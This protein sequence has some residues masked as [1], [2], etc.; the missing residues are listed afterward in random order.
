M[1]RLDDKIDAGPMITYPVL[2]ESDFKNFEFQERALQYLSIAIVQK[3]KMR[4]AIYCPLEKKGDSS[5]WHTFAEPSLPTSATPEQ[6][7]EMKTLVG[8]GNWVMPE[9]RALTGIVHQ[10]VKEHSKNHCVLTGQSELKNCIQKGQFEFGFSC[11]YD[12]ITG[13]FSIIFRSTMQY[14]EHKIAK[15]A[16]HANYYYENI[17]IDPGQED[18]Y[19]RQYTLEFHIER[20]VELFIMHF[21]ANAFTNAINQYLKKHHP[22]LVKKEWV[23][24]EETYRENYTLKYHKSWQTTRHN[25]D[26]LAEAYLRTTYISSSLRDGVRSEFWPKESDAEVAATCIKLALELGIFFDL[27]DIPREFRHH[28]EKTAL[29]QACRKTTS[30]A[31]MLVMNL[32]ENGASINK[33]IAGLTALDYARENPNKEII[34]YLETIMSLITVIQYD[35]EKSIDTYLNPN[36]I[37]ID[38]PI[39]EGMTPLALSV[40]D[41]SLNATLSILRILEANKVDF[42]SSKKG[43]YLKYQS[44]LQVA[45][46]DKDFKTLIFLLNVGLD[47]ADLSLDNNDS[48]KGVSGTVITNW[49]KPDWVRSFL[50]NLIGDSVGL[51]E[52]ARNQRKLISTKEEIKC[53][54]KFKKTII[55]ARKIVNLKDHA[56]ECYWKEV[57]ALARCAFSM[58]ELLSQKP[59][60]TRQIFLNTLERVFGDFRALIPKQDLIFSP[61]VIFPVVEVTREDENLFDK[62][63]FTPE[64]PF[65][66]GSTIASL[67]SLNSEKEKTPVLDFKSVKPVMTMSEVT[68]NSQPLSVTP[69]PDPASSTRRV[70]TTTYSHP[71]NE[72]PMLPTLVLVTGY[73]APDRKPENYLVKVLLMGDNDLKG[74]FLKAVSNNPRRQNFASTMGI[75]NET[76]SIKNHTFQIWDANLERYRTFSKSTVRGYSVIL[77]F[78]D[79]STSWMRQFKDD[80]NIRQA[81]IPQYLDS[82]EVILKLV[83]SN[84]SE[85][86]PEPMAVGKD[87]HVYASNLLSVASV[88]IRTKPTPVLANLNP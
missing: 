67:F 70:S 29:I 36:V 45:A 9:T 42:R 71:E 51:A 31:P 17:K 20:A 38:R 56:P 84:D 75:Q 14:K 22:H 81:Y 34:T 83:G 50:D 52:A 15:F 59:A 16:R 7:T 79:N 10:E 27:D 61:Q 78:G 40:K 28:F 18:F 53:F 5:I 33:R 57:D 3:R 48:I 12:P 32:I 76:V 6:K 25:K 2:S 87:W 30:D 44:P 88:K 63:I 26:L 66:L 85:Q 62:E 82:G 80:L 8:D 21:F 60:N 77:F 24:L 73:K 69:I 72:A 37:M 43:R 39:Y 68:T 47:H 19:D 55:H 41:H 46:D 54:Q 23:D 13:K 64:E 65:S 58:M 74:E 4:Y 1:S 11:T 35:D 49:S 86:I